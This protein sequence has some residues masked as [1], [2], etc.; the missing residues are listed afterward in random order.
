MG[1]R[2]GNDWTGRKRAFLTDF[3]IRINCHNN[4]YGYKYVNSLY[5]QKRGY[6]LNECM[7]KANT[8]TVINSSQNASEKEGNEF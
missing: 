1:F 6:G 3:I 5:D 7:I 2:E 8:V 4:P